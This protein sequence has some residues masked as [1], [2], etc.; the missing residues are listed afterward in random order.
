M[1]FAI[2]FL[3]VVLGH[4]IGPLRGNR[5]TG[6]IRVSLT[7]R[8]LSLANLSNFNF[9]FIESGSNRLF[10]RFFLVNGVRQLGRNL[11]VFHVSVNIR[12]LAGTIFVS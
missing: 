7:L 3:L 12:R 6:K 2:P 8:S 9:Y 5:V 11:Y 4:L 10:L 1:F